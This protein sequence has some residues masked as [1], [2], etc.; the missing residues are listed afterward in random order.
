MTL[1]KGTQKVCPIVTVGTTPTLTTKNIT[2]NG[3]YNASSDNADGY[4]SVTVNV[5]TVTPTGTISINSNGTYDVTN[6]ASADVSVSGGGGGNVAIVQADT[7]SF[8]K[9]LAG[10]DLS[11][12]GRALFIIVSSTDDVLGGFIGGDDNDYSMMSF[13]S[14][15][16]ALEGED[17]IIILSTYSNS[18][19]EYEC[20]TSSGHYYIGNLNFTYTSPFS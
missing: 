12:N 1:Y 15:G 3:T 19:F 9:K 20:M 11:Y 5:P 14:S 18:R 17:I 16:S 8:T 10:E 4:S 7:Y 6:Y 2:Q 13:S